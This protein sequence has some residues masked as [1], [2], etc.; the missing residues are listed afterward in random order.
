[1]T[2]VFDVMVKNVVVVTPKVT[3]KNA[4]QKMIENGV[5]SLVVTEGDKIRGIITR[6]DL[7][8]R[9]IVKE[10]NPSSTLVKNIMTKKVETIESEKSILEALRLMKKQKYS[11]LPVVKEEKLVGIVSL[12]SALNYIAKFFLISGWRQD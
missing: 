6:S 3:V 12:S 2:K 4:G 9:V 8:D 10:L 7:V 11:Q 1:M 5:S